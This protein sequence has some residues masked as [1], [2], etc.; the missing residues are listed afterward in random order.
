MITL[1]IKALVDSFL[2]FFGKN[3]LIN[4]LMFYHIFWKII[5]MSST[6]IIWEGV[7]LIFQ[8]PF[9]WIIFGNAFLETPIWDPSLGKPLPRIELPR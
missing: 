6:N 2:S 7:L 3:K 8:D 9:W 4:G 1:F 5:I